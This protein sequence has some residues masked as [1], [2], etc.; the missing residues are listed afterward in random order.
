MEAIG[1]RKLVVSSLTLAVGVGVA[2]YKGDVPPGLL[3]LLEVV[4]VGYTLG[5][6]GVK[7]FGKNFAPG[8]EIR[9]EGPPQEVVVN[10]PE[11]P[12]VPSPAPV[13]DISLQAIKNKQAITDSKI[14]ELEKAVNNIVNILLEANKN[15]AESKRIV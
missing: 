7:V 4:A 3:Q 10:L 1:G 2:L 14:S 12:L 8:E 9:T 13:E 5:N 6:V 15:A 11:T